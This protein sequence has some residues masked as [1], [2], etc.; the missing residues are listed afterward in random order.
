MSNVLEALS[1]TDTAT[2]GQLG[3]VGANGANLKILTDNK[4]VKLVKQKDPAQVKHWS[5]TGAGKKALKSGEY[6]IVE[7]V[8]A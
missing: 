5:I 4:L 1:K 3:A 7:K 8:A 6:T 2:F